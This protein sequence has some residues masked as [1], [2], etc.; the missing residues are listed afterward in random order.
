MPEEP[1]SVGFAASVDPLGGENFLEGMIPE[2]WEDHSATPKPPNKGRGLGV[3]V[4]DSKR[5]KASTNGGL[6][7]V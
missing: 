2:G 7:G 4:K 1:G 3:S 6:R 5:A